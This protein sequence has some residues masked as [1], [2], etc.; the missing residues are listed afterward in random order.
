M[1]E[2]LKYPSDA[3]ILRLCG[4]RWKAFTVCA[5]PSIVTRIGALQ[6]RRPREGHPES[7]QEPE[8]AF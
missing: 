2:P 6:E 8:I 7:S 1:A 3:S 4:P 5:Q